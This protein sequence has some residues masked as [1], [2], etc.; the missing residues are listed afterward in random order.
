MK[1]RGMLAVLCALSL[2]LVACGGSSTSAPPSAEPTTEATATTESTTDET[3]SPDST[4]VVTSPVGTWKVAGFETGGISMTGNIAEA[5]T[6]FGG[7]DLA[8]QFSKTQ[9][10]LKEDGTGTFTFGSDALTLVWEESGGS[11]PLTVAREDGSAFV[12]SSSLEDGKLRVVL[13]E[14]EGAVLIMTPDGSYPNAV[15]YDKSAAKPISSEAD[16]LGSWNVEAIVVSGVTITG[17]PGAISEQFGFGDPTV[18]FSEGGKVSMF[19]DDTTYAIEADGASI[20]DTADASVKVP[21][22]KLDGSLLIDMS[23]LMNAEMLI[24]LSK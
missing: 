7:E 3:T 22:L 24:V 9:V 14:E 10:E 19:G 2:A 6:L 13:D 23:D 21:V 11:I 17:D 12:V 4:P 16:L 15:T 5:M 18:A 20:F 8:D 1:K